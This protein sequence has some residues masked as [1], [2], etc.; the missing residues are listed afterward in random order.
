[1]GFLTGKKALITG[2]ASDRSIA[3][4]TAQAMA[5]E[6]AELAFT[7]QGDK[8]RDRVRDMAEQLGSS[9]C[10]PMD[11]SSDEEITAVFDEL[12]GSWDTLDSI[13]HSIGFA[14]RDQ[15]KGPFLET[16]NREG[17]QVAHDISSYS[18]IALAK[19]GRSMLSDTS[20]LV[21]L[22]YLGAV[23]A[24]PNYNIMGPAKASLE[25]NVR[26]LAAD[27]GKFGIRVN[28]ISAGPIKTLAAMGIGDFRSMAS[29]FEKVAPLR[30]AVTTTEVG[31][32]VAFLCS[33]LA[34]GITGEILYVDAGYNVLGFGIG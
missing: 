27:L 3:W 8:I 16:V 6:G 19:A 5:R 29:Q 1:M 9:I 32:A 11:V 15:M 31:N 21:T 23:R 4:G 34:S 2:I 10:L 12:K 26:F 25:A 17:S 28:G 24:I 30:R 18:F 14:P 20:S 22:S 13:V 33:D 7:Y